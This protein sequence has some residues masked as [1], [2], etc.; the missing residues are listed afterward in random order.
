MALPQTVRV[1]LSSE[2]AESIS[3]TPVVVQELPVRE[4]VEHMLGVTGK[5]EARIRDLLLRG[6]L[7]SGASRFRWAGWEQDAES[8]RELLATFPDPDPSRRFD[9]AGCVKVVLRGGRSPIEIPREAAARKSLFQRRTFW[10]LLMQVV[11]EGAIAYAGY[12]YRDRSDRYTR[13]VTPGEMQ[14]IRAAAETVRFSTL[15]EQIRMVGFLSAELHV[16]RE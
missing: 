11:S 14:R 15:R 5:D 4:L 1:K 8:L 2:A 13:A 16:K 3:L 12:S 10:E 7:V 6:S 9:A